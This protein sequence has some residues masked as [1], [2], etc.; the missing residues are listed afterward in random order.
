MIISINEWHKR[1]LEIAS[2]AKLKKDGAAINMVLIVTTKSQD[3]QL[4]VT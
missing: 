4:V 2:H 3:P 1:C